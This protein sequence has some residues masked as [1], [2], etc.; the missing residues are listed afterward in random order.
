MSDLLTVVVLAFPQVV[1]SRGYGDTHLDKKRKVEDFCKCTTEAMKANDGQGYH[2][3]LWTYKFGCR[4][5]HEEKEAVITA[6]R[7]FDP[8]NLSNH[9]ILLM[10]GGDTF[11]EQVTK[12]NGQTYEQ[13]C[14]DQ[15]D[16]FQQLLAEFGGRTVLFDNFTADQARQDAQLDRLLELVDSLPS[17]GTRF[18]NILFQA[19]SSELRKTIAASGEH[20]IDQSIMKSTSL[21]MDKFEECRRQEEQQGDGLEKWYGLIDRCGALIDYIGETRWPGMSSMKERIARFRTTVDDFIEAKGRQEGHEDQ[22]RSMLNAKVKLQ[23]AYNRAKDIRIGLIVGGVGVVG[24][25]F[26]LAG[27]LSLIALY[28]TSPAVIAKVGYDICALVSSDKFQRAAYNFVIKAYGVYQ[29][30]GSV[31]SFFQKIKIK[32]YDE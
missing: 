24:G 32:F 22:W 2:A 20:V 21:L 1:D 28:P 11:F 23:D 26:I 17:A 8:Q 29:S 4:L 25:T 3:F 14:A 16:D 9:G 6:K 10:T 18:S 5:T 7:I 27:A 31:Y 12:R 30:M 13:W 15:G 19:A